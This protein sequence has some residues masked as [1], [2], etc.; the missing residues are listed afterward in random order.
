[1]H[2]SEHFPEMCSL[3]TSVCSMNV[4]VGAGALTRPVVRSA[5]LWRALLAHPDEGVRAYVA[6]GSR[7]QEFGN[8]TSRNFRL[9]SGV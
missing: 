4:H 6:N 7:L 9:C 8:R 2:L 1:M 3:G 5:T